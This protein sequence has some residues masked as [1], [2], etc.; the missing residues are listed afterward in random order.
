MT[1]KDGCRMMLVLVP[2]GEDSYPARH[3]GDMIWAMTYED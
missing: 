2:P 3:Q 1:N